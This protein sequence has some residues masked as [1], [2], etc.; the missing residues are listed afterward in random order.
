MKNFFLFFVL[1][2]AGTE[3]PAQID[4]TW[5]GQQTASP[6]NSLLENILGGDDTHVYALK[7]KSN[8]SGDANRYYIDTY[9]KKSLGLISTTA[10]NLPVQTER[11]SFW[12]QFFMHA[13]KFRTSQI[14]KVIYLNGKF[15]V[16]S[17]F[18]SRNKQ[19]NYAYV[20]TISEKGQLNPEIHPVDSIVADSK[21][22]TG[23][24]KIVLS[25]DKKHFLVSHTEPLDMYPFERF[26]CKIL[27]EDLS[28]FWKKDFELPYKDKQFH[29]AKYC[30]DSAGN[31]FIL[32]NIDKDKENQARNKPAYRYSI[33]AYFCKRD[34]LREY[35]IDLGDKYISEITCDLNAA[36]DLICAGFYSKNSESSQAGTFF[37]KIDKTSTEVAERNI[38]EFD[39]DFLMEFMTERKVDKGKELYNFDI[40]YLLLRDDGSAVMIAEQYFMDIV[41]YYNPASRSYS[42]AYHYYYN[43]IIV[44][45][46]DPKGQTTLLKKISKYQHTVNDGGPYSSF[47]LVDG[48]DMLHFIYNDNPDNSH[49]SESEIAHGHVENMNNPG[50]SVV[51]MVSMDMKGNT[52]R[53]QL[54]DNHARKNKC[55][56]RPKMNKN[57]TEKDLILFSGTGKYYRLGRVTL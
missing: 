34:Q 26:S 48:K 18:Y 31:L 49:R 38:H 7:V 37:L 32:V 2:F 54:L 40:H 14:E 5:G 21:R 9:S 27:N 55:W 50:R 6:K 45:G 1:L 52:Q 42:Y 23:L 17:S 33:F 44:V 35:T 51:V 41:S 47:V 36:G 30:L 22:N 3:T 19:M 24:F 11:S 46:F 13:G 12:E 56:F 16:F 28:P 43:D 53:T 8:G 10:Y 15:F 57:I 39:K 20:Q 4:V 29:I 25:A